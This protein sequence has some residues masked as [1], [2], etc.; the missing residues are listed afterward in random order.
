MKNKTEEEFL[1]LLGRFFMEYLPNTVNASPNTI[2]S[3]KC[4]FRLLFQYFRDNTG[5]KLGGITFELLNFELLT[6]FFDWLITDR[7]N[8]RTTAKQRMG[9]LA[10]FADYAE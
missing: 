8:S 6:C 9:A 1:I 5:I 2:T 3:Y 10:S 4:A 7:G